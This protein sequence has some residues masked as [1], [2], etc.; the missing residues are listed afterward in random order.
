MASLLLCRIRI[1]R[2]AILVF[3]RE[4]DKSTA[5]FLEEFFDDFV[6]SSGVELACAIESEEVGL[7][8]DGVVDIVFQ[9]RI[10]D[11][12]SGIFFR[13]AE[14]V[15]LDDICEGFC[16]VACGGVHACTDTVGETVDAVVIRQAVVNQFCVVIEEFGRIGEFATALNGWNPNVS[17]CIWNGA[18]RRM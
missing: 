2:F 7:F 11:T 15:A 8:D 16:F 13:I 5:G 17:C 4:W 12:F 3:H 18:H 1:Y 9:L 14:T 10:S 6:L